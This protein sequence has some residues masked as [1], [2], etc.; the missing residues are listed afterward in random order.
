MTFRL[1]TLA[2]S[3][4][5]SSCTP[6]VKYALSS[7]ALRFS[8]GQYRDR[9]FGHGNPPAPQPAHGDPS[10]PTRTP[11]TLLP[12][13][14]ARTGR[15]CKTDPTTGCERLSGRTKLAATVIQRTQQFLGRGGSLRGI[16]RQQ[17]AAAARPTHAGDVLRGELLDRQVEACRVIAQFRQRAA[18]ERHPT[19]E[20][21]TRGS[22]PGCKRVRARVH[23]VAGKLLRAGKSRRTHETTV[24]SGPSRRVPPPPWPSRNR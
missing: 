3:A 4:R 17:A 11:T 19:R 6:S 20:G 23:R 13:A 2:R 21:C 7:S 18:R 24:G 1:A 9:L 16:D 10:L 8:K 14:N 15:G 22:R 12:A 5:I